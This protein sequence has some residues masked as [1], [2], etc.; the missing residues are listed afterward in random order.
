MITPEKLWEVVAKEYDCPTEAAGAMTLV[1][2]NRVATALEKLLAAEPQPRELTDEEINTYI[3]NEFGLA[4]D[5]TNSKEKMRRTARWAIEE[6]RP[7]VCGPTAKD[8]W[9]KFRVIDTFIDFSHAWEYHVKSITDVT[10]PLEDQIAE[11]KRANTDWCN[12]CY[13]GRTAK[14]RIAELE[15]DNR[16]LKSSWKCQ[17]GALQQVNAELESQLTAAKAEYER[18]HNDVI[19]IVQMSCGVSWC[20][21][22]DVIGK[23]CGNGS[24]RCEHKIEPKADKPLDWKNMAINERLEAVGC[25]PVN[26]SDLMLT[27]HDD[28]TFSIESRTKPPCMTEEE[29]REVV[30]KW[31][32]AIKELTCRPISSDR[33][34]GALDATNALAGH[35]ADQTAEVKRQHSVIVEDYIK[36]ELLRC[37]VAKWKGL[38]DDRGQTICHLQTCLSKYNRTTP[39]RLEY[40]QKSK[41]TE[42][43]VKILGGNMPESEE[44]KLKPKPEW[45]QWRV[46][47]RGVSASDNAQYARLDSLDSLPVFF[48]A[49]G[50]PGGDEKYLWHD[51]RKKFNEGSVFWLPIPSEPDAVRKW[52]EE[53]EW[54]KYVV[55]GGEKSINNLRRLDGSEEMAVCFG[56]NGTE[57]RLPGCT[58]EFYLNGEGKNTFSSIPTP[59]AEAMIAEA[60]E[61]AKP[62]ER[63]YTN[64]PQHCVWLYRDIGVSQ[65]WGSSGMHKTKWI[66][67]ESHLSHIRITKSEAEAIMAGWKKEEEK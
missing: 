23:I 21:K 22:E 24:G 15:E 43:V 42:M 41:R 4:Y 1:H 60:K 61:R 62:T 17:A 8:V 45:P 28:D 40:F 34:L 56:D 59:E 66:D 20:N 13:D 64:E 48:H 50:S 32:V 58:S 65:V 44:D 10:E 14:E 19:S 55:M 52:R 6:S 54:P 38:A 16:R 47:Y 11:L 37:A 30:V 49:D 18:Q 36:I 9:G 29:M 2:W 3:K 57:K 33:V 53:N 5:G 46:Y 25:R 35:V 67:D 26:D 51:S 39:E 7:A 63:W 12:F 31:Q 27:L